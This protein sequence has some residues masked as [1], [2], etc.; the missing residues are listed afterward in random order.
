MV[1]GLS[2]LCRGF[3]VCVF[4][5]M[6]TYHQNPEHGLN[7]RLTN[8]LIHLVSGVVL[9]PIGGK[10]IVWCSEHDEADW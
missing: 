9:L 7:Q 6:S 4:S 2:D 1:M 5:D 10:C 8:T 3:A